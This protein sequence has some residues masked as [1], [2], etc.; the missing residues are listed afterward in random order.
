MTKKDIVREIRK[1][2]KVQDV[3]ISKTAEGKGQIQ[4]TCWHGDCQ[5]ISQFVMQYFPK[6]V[7]TCSACHFFREGRLSI[8]FFKR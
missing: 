7:F 3:E 8:F 6:Q 5:R 4:L 2:Y 1:R